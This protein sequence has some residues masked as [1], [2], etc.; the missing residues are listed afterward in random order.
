MK[1]FLLLRYNE[2]PLRLNSEDIAAVFPHS[3]GLI[4]VKYYSDGQRI[5][6]IGHT[7]IQK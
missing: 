2:E 1:E 3:A 6:A 5:S 7:L 4:E